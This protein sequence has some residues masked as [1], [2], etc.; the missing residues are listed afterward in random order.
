MP[1]DRLV[2]R[3]PRGWVRIDV[4]ASG[5]CYADLGTVDASEGSVIFP[6]VP[7]H[8]IAGVLAD[9]GEGVGGWNLGDRVSVGWFGGSCGHCEMCRVGDVV[10]CPERKVP[11]LS[12]P[13]GWA[14][15]VTVPADALCRIPEE[16]SFCDAA[17]MGCAGVTTFNAIR[18]AQLTAGATVAVFGVGGLGHLAVQFAA[19]MGYRTIAIARG[20]DRESLARDLGAREYIDSAGGQAGSALAALGGA[21]LI[22][23]TA[24]STE[25]VA[26]LLDGLRVHGR[27]T[28][29]GVDSGSIEVPV[30]QMVRRNQTVT[31]H[32]TGSAHDIELTM[33]FASTNNVRPII[34]RMPLSQ[35]VEGLARLKAGAARF[36]IVFDTGINR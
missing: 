10:H 26:D 19:A 18:S 31:G 29:I 25:V 36:R 13:G 7:G 14:Q 20:V 27:L 12:Y 6:V 16:M 35:A 33:R 15:S 24:S 23:C 17:P 30:A 4:V 22:L 5:L 32:L 34:E 1:S 11:G 8:E 9:L 28:L 3:P 21:D 2:E